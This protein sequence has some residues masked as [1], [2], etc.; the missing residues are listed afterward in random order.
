MLDQGPLTSGSRPYYHPLLL[1]VSEILNTGLSNLPSPSAYTNNTFSLSAIFLAQVVLFHF[2]VIPSFSQCFFTI[3]YLADRPMGIVNLVRCR[4]L[5]L[6]C[7][8]PTLEQGPSIKACKIN[9]LCKCI[10]GKNPTMWF[11]NR[12]NT[13]PAIQAQKIAR[14]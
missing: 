12:P 4:A 2:S 7:L 5:K 6:I 1:F 8:R 13:N 9:E 11:S 3:P 14:G 10:V